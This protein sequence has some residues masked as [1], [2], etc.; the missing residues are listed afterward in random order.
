MTSKTIPSKA[1]VSEQQLL[2]AD[3]NEAIKI[4]INITENLIDFSEREAQALAQNDLMSIAIMQDEKTIITER[5]V[6]LST[7]FRRRLEQFRGSDSAL[8]DRLEALQKTL[9][10]NSRHNNKMFDQIQN[11]AKKKTEAVLMNAHKLGQ[12]CPVKFGNETLLMLNEQ[13]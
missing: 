5:Y 10:E 4:M 7:E 2:P 12:S 3:K 13:Q 6:A 11:K 8:L 9:G 1:A